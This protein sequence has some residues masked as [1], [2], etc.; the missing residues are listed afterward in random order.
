MRLLVTDDQFQIRPVP[1]LSQGSQLEFNY[2]NSKV[3][4]RPVLPDEPLMPIFQLIYN[5]YVEEQKVLPSNALS[6]ECR[7]ARA[8]WDEWDFLASTRHYI[9]L[10]NDE[11][12][13][14]ARIVNDSELGLPLERT[15]FDLSSE[16]LCGHE[17][18]EFSK[19]VIRQSYRGSPVL[20]A[21]TWQIHQQKKVREKRSCI[22][23]SCD[24]AF[25]K[26]YRHMG[27]TEI[28]TFHS[29]EFDAP[30]A[31]MRMDFAPSFNEH[32]I[33]GPR[34]YGRKDPELP[35]LSKTSFQ[36]YAE[37]LN[38]GIR[39]DTWKSQQLAAGGLDVGGVWRLSASGRASNNDPVLWSC[40]AKTIRRPRSGAH[41]DDERT[42]HEVMRY[43]DC[44]LPASTHLKMPR[45]LDVVQARQT[46]TLILEDIYDSATRA[47]RLSDLQ[48]LA[49]RLGL[50]HARDTGSQ[51]DK[52]GSWLREYVRHAEPLVAALPTYGGQMDMLRELT[53][54]PVA[55][56]I[57]NIWAHRQMLLATLDALPQANC[58]QDVTAG[59]V[60]VREGA[61]RPIYYLLDWATAGMSA[62]GAELGPLI[63]GSSILMHWNIETANL[64]LGPCIDAYRRGLL[65]N[66]VNVDADTLKLGFMASAS[67]RYIAWG[68][69][70]VE[71]VW[72]PAQHERALKVTGHSV[73]EL[74]ANYCNVRRQL[75]AW[76]EAAIA[77][78]SPTTFA[79]VG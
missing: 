57:S 10:T 71:S 47:L 30:Y 38:A 32:V 68:G 9:A 36:Q 37:Q 60:A 4:V 25:V 53:A 21:F 16:R 29:S 58:H 54:E 28:G 40:V 42:T 72:N 35:P 55:G 51:K 43:Q 41:L 78:S 62:L 7:A 8:K 11:I 19:L 65:S 6:N 24:P 12:I 13:G 44:H 74:I 48:D 33:D 23:M 31:A 20:S 15:G 76:G 22:Y 59:N 63:V 46:Q 61:G 66:G 1:S 50:W 18:C 56:Q 3:T 75:A 70:R 79:S 73:R 45:L 5:V 39:I 34:M 26:V 17:V 52:R 64:V 2:R 14:H 69:H 77:L 27:A 67:V 49:E